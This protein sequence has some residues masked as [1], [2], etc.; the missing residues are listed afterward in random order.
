[1]AAPLSPSQKYIKALCLW[2]EWDTTAA[3]GV[4]ICE[5]LQE[6]ACA[7]LEPAGGVEGAGAGLIVS[8]VASGGHS[9]S[10]QPLDQQPSNPGGQA[11]FLAEAAAM[12]EA[13]AGYVEN[14]ETWARCIAGQTKGLKTIQ[15]SYCGLRTGCC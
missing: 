9:A 7:T 4:T 6:K 12:C 13:C 10:F 5:F 8:S 11:E 2:K 15:K 14:K 1:V 3:E